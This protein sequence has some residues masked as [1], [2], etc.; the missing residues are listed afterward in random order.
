MV[1]H[2]KSTLVNMENIKYIIVDKQGDIKGHYY[3][4]ESLLTIPNSMPFDT[5]EVSIKMDKHPISA[6]RERMGIIKRLRKFLCNFENEKV[7]VHFVTGDK[8]YTQPILKSLFTNNRRVVATIHRVPT[9]RLRIALL[10]HFSKKVNLIECYSEAAKEALN[11]IGIKNVVCIAHP[12]FYNYEKLDNRENLKQK[13]NVSDKVVISALGGTRYDKG[14]DIL[15]NAIGLLPDELKER[16]LLFI[17]GRE[18]DI[19]RAQ[20]QT[21]V[22]EKK[23]NAIIRLEDVEDTVFHEIVKLTDIMA[24]PYRSCF[25]SAASGPMTEAMSLGIPC[26]F[27]GDGMLGYY[28]KFHAGETFATEDTESMTKAIE[29]MM[30]QPGKVPEATKKHFSNAEFLLKHINLYNNMFSTN[31][32][33]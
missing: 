32:R 30:L 2:Q 12:T 13:Y 28:S 7:V 3:I 22:N 19:T 4:M 11:N 8:F 15:I 18:Q 14:L 16:L 9:S 24:I 25:N 33:L 5:E 21:A 10:R 23:I 1:T 20:I 31:G 6:I 27:P 17:A 29:R 26:L